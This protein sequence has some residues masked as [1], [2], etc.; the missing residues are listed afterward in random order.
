VGAPGAGACAGAVVEPVAFVVPV[1][2]VAP[3]APRKGVLVLRAVPGV[4]EPGVGETLW[5]GRITGVFALRVVLRAPLAD[6]SGVSV[7]GARLAGGVEAAGAGVDVD[8][9]PFVSSV[10]AALSPA[11]VLGRL[12][13]VSSGWWAGIR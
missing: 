6:E 12:E 7:A 5:S 1:V 9:D 2:P 4:T 10:E 8:E 13:G 11:L 3:L